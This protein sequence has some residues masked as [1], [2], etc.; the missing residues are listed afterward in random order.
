MYTTYITAMLR[1]AWQLKAQLALIS[2]FL[3]VSL[4]FVGHRFDLSIDVPIDHVC[5]LENS[6][7]GRARCSFFF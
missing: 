5:L 4:D 3:S 6:L 1:A 7:D 2:D